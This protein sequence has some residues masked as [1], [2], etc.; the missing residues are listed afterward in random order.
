MVASLCCP[1]SR[2][3]KASS[4]GE[5][6]ST[7]RL[8]SSARSSPDAAALVPAALVPA[9]P[10][11]AALVPAVLVPAVPVLATPVTRPLRSRVHRGGHL[12]HDGTVHAQQRVDRL[13]PSES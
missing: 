1:S 7:P 6:N 4:R 9:V 8:D 11:P 13:G 10:V 12:A 2:T 5:E 3:R